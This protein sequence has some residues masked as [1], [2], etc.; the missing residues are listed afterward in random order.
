MASKIAKTCTHRVLLK[1]KSGSWSSVCWCL[2]GF[3][4]TSELTSQAG[5]SQVSVTES[6]WGVCWVETNE[7]WPHPC[8][9]V[10]K[11]SLLENGCT[12]TLPT[13]SWCHTC[14]S[15]PDK[16][17]SLSIPMF[18]ESFWQVTQFKWA[19][20]RL[21]RKTQQMEAPGWS[22]MRQTRCI[23]SQTHHID[24]FDDKTK[25]KHSPWSSFLDI[26]CSLGWVMW[27]R[28]REC[29][30]FTIQQVQTRLGCPHTGT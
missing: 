22:I 1:G 5:V 8:L 9:N 16:I 2:S 21:F 11:Y 27:A 17:T 4:P 7:F 30:N 19:L 15:L 3:L 13:S 23:F 25:W 28:Q 26:I 14:V 20:S 10:S 6:A 29:G 12:S 18:A 24:T